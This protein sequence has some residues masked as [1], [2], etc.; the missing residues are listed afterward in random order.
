[1]FYQYLKFLFQFNEKHIITS[2]N[3]FT[4]ISHQII[5]IKFFCII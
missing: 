4:I 1:M 3:Y 5:T 2:N